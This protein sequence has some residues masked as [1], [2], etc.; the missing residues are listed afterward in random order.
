MERENVA[1]VNGVV[2]QMTSRKREKVILSDDSLSLQEMADK[3]NTT[4]GTVAY[5]R[6]RLIEEGKIDRRIEAKDKGYTEKLYGILHNGP[7]TLPEIREEW[8]DDR[9]ASIGSLIHASKDIKKAGN[10]R[11]YVYYLSSHKEEAEQ[12]ASAIESDEPKK[13]RVDDIVNSVIDS[14]LSDMGIS[15]G[16]YT[17]VKKRTREIVS[18]FVD[19]VQ[20]VWSSSVEEVANGAV[21]VALRELGEMIDPV[22]GYKR[23]VK[24][25]DSYST[26]HIKYIPA[27]V[28]KIGAGSEVTNRALEIAKQISGPYSG[29][30]IGVAGAITYLT[31]KKKELDC[32]YKEIASSAPVSAP[33]ISNWVSKLG[34]VVG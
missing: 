14:R 28:N 31:M 5:R 1:C 23:A 7:K 32:T 12:K 10:R 19:S 3:L 29:S 34:E 13:R 21:V 2:I 27:M 25:A 26:S 18:R 33:T 6:S 24:F 15:D 16:K 22:D 8:K 4:K 30:P 9:P 17:Y 11:H 20:N